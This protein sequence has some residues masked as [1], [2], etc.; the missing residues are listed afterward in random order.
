MTD[1]SPAPR[2]SHLA[3]VWLDLRSRL[4]A[5]WPACSPDLPSLEAFSN[6]TKIKN[7]NN[8]HLLGTCCVSITY[9]TTRYRRYILGV[10]G[11]YL[12]AR[13]LGFKSQV[14][15]FNYTVGQV[16]LPPWPQCLHL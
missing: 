1:S 13:F 9:P 10:N 6:R 15:S 5:Q 16:T 14:P 8:Y 4:T 11:L 12:G 3:Q 2:P 7:D